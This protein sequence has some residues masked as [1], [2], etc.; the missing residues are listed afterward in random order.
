M[1]YCRY[2]GELINEDFNERMHGELVT[3]ICQAV[4]NSLSKKVKGEITISIGY[5]D[6]EVVIDNGEH[7]FYT[8]ISNVYALALKGDLV[9]E[10]TARIIRKYSSFITEIFFN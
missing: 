7:S 1:L 3:L 10:L 6:F 4:Y 8:H 5:D 9:P 2:T